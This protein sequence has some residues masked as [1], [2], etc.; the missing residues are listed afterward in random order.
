MTIFAQGSFIIPKNVMAD[1]TL[2]IS[3]P[4]SAERINE[5]AARAAA[6]VVIAITAAGVA[7]NNYILFVLLALD[8]G[9]R[10]FASG[11]ASPVRFLAKQIVQL[12]HIAPK[13]ADAA[14]K[15]FAAGVGL[16]FSAA[17]AAFIFAGLTTA[18]FVTAGV[19]LFCALLE[20]AFGIC[21]GCIVYTFTVLPFIKNK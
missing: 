15:K 18:A 4:V 7:F 17:I 1:S 19:L 21:L 16:V 6:F 20:G 10:A 3:C 13:P 12:L 9:L 11:N 8:F 2:N 14:P 5:N